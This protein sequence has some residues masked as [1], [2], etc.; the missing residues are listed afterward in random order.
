[1]RA[2]RATAAR[3]ARWSALRWRSAPSPRAREA[4]A[5]A[6]AQLLSRDRPG[7]EAFR[8]AWPSTLCGPDRRGNVVWYDKLADIDVHK[9]AALPPAVV[10]AGRAQQLECVQ[11]RKRRAP[12]AV[13]QSMHVYILDC[14]GGGLPLTPSTWRVIREMADVGANHYAATLRRCYVINAHPAA[15]LAWAALR[16]IIHPLTLARVR[17]VAD[18]AELR[19]LA[20]ADGLL[21]DEVLIPSLGGAC[22]DATP[23]ARD[24]TDMLR[25]A[26][27]TKA[28]EASAPPTPR[29][30]P[31]LN[32][33][34]A[35]EE[36]AA[37]PRAA[38]KSKHMKRQRS[39]TSSASASRGR[40]AAPREPPRKG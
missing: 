30:E 18:L 23:L 2:P 32:D 25:A 22:K 28:M 6:R 34:P 29:T 7:C 27:A 20:A 9:L 39:N 24:V 21:V 19:R 14:A 37:L 35:A 26:Q 36:A 1:M 17:I 8:A 31:E 16:V 33:A 15:R 3:S 10:E 5:L 38:R 13:Q 12:P 40:M 4:D 11:A